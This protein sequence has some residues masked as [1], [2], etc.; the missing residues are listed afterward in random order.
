M[1]H[2]VIQTAA[3]AV[4]AFFSSGCATMFLRQTQELEV[5][6]D[7]PGATATTGDAS[8]ATPGKLNVRRQKGEVVIRIEKEGFETR[9]VSLKFGRAGAIWAA[10]AFFLGGLAGGVVKDAADNFNLFGPSGNKTSAT[11][12]GAAVGAAV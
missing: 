6:T 1:K 9:L 7:P 11:T 4:L 10:S 3:V 8:V 5:V 12:T 2:R